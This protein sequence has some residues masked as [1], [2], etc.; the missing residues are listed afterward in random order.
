M[1]CGLSIF[2]RAGVQP[3]EASWA[4]SDRSPSKRKA[5]TRWCLTC[6]NYFL[7]KS[8]TSESSFYF[9]CSHPIVFFFLRLQKCSQS[10][11]LPG[12]HVCFVI[13][14]VS[15][16]PILTLSSLFL[17]LRIFLLCLKRMQNPCF[18]TALHTTTHLYNTQM[19][20]LIFIVDF[21][22]GL[23]KDWG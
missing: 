15:L 2:R 5:V 6:G 8:G 18:F 19:N 9:L 23:L 10:K 17:N 4:R 3:A 12:N 20:W 16:L 1:L 13:M 22:V 11:S 21:L 14:M 7:S